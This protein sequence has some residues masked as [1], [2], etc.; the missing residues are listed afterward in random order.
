MTVVVII[1][2]ILV[3]L[4]F[5]SGVVATILVLLQRS[6]SDGT[7]ALSGSG[8]GKDSNSFYQRNKGMRKESVYKMWTFI[9]SAVLAVCS[10]VFFILG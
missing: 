1:R 2:I 8:S 10:I 9:C 6:N 3:I 4:M 7:S 5:L